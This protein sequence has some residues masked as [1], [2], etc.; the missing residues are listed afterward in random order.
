MPLR[1]G[2]S[3]AAPR[4]QA[5]ATPIRMS[6]TAE[7]PLGWLYVE[8]LV[9]LALL[10]PNRRDKA[11]EHFLL[12]LPA[13][14]KKPA[15]LSAL[16]PPARDVVAAV[17]ATQPTVPALTARFRRLAAL[18]PEM[19]E[20][21]A[22]RQWSNQA[23][24]L[25]RL[26]SHALGDPDEAFEALS[27]VRREP[28]PAP[29]EWMH[30]PVP[31]PI[32]WHHS[33]GASGGSGR[34]HRHRRHRARWVAAAV[35]LVC[36]AGA[37]W[38]FY[39][40]DLVLPTRHLAEVARGCAVRDALGGDIWFGAT[41]LP[42]STRITRAEACAVGE[43]LAAKTHEFL[44]VRVAQVCDPAAEIVR[45]RFGGD[46][47]AAMA[48]AQQLAAAGDANAA[49]AYATLA[50]CRTEESRAGLLEDA[51]RELAKAEIHYGVFSVGQFVADGRTCR[52]YIEQVRI[53][54]RSARAQSPDT[55]YGLSGLGDCAAFRFAPEGLFDLSRRLEGVLPGDYIREAFRYDG[56]LPD[57]WTFGGR[58]YN[59]VSASRD[60][61]SRDVGASP[62]PRLTRP[63]IDVPEGDVL[64]AFRGISGFEGSRLRDLLA[65]PGLAS[66]FWSVVPR[67][68]EA[69][70]VKLAES[71]GPFRRASDGALFFD[72][73]THAD[74][75]RAFAAAYLHPAGLIHLA[76]DVAGCGRA[77]P[78]IAYFASSDPTELRPAVMDAWLAAA[79]KPGTEAFWETDAGRRP[80]MLR[81]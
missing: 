46:Y 7:R 37:A 23:R 59:F 63:A 79:A 50:R 3:I 49:R 81:R 75:S 5:I 12:S 25:L 31:H 6:Q 65:D 34:R 43:T 45:T 39:A 2:T 10:F 18:M 44:R 29:D 57:T 36:A 61:S 51:R 40:R 30:P 15:G 80:L 11:T 69:C 52:G 73:P 67:G 78:G 66:A 68:Y 41:P 14:V 8:S 24:Y 54:S 17:K 20:P 74:G 76:I 47:S 72:A 4:H 21:E 1:G 70:A 13:L 64:K 22:A 42:E 16:L 33:H 27:P 9:I 53:E 56:V 55:R 28:A 58:S 32:D 62:V 26:R 38:W 77:G 48:H 19:L 35:V 71:I 60:A